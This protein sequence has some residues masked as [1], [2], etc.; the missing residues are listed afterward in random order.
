[1]ERSRSPTRSIVCS[2]R[3]LYPPLFSDNSLW[4]RASPTGSQVSGWEASG[5]D[6][7]QVLGV[8]TP[9]PGD[10]TACAVVQKTQLLQ[11]LH[12][13]QGDTGRA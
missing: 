2:K 13:F 11:A 3:I 12:S 1:M 7:L 4:E 8:S 6:P 10:L 9:T 5:P